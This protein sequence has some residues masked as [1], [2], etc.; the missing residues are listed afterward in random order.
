MSRDISTKSRHR[1]KNASFLKLLLQMILN[2][3]WEKF[4][5]SKLII[6]SW[7]MISIKSKWGWE[8]LKTI[9]SNINLFSTNIQRSKNKSMWESRQSGSLKLWMKS[10]RWLSK[11][12]LISTRNGDFRKEDCLNKSKN[13]LSKH[14]KVKWGELQSWL[15]RESEVRKQSKDKFNSPKKILKI[16]RSS[17]DLI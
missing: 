11:I 9:N 16:G 13:G 15:K 3:T 6:L 12:E 14:K 2:F 4:G 7:Q 10:C 1:L 17:I 8:E 5:G